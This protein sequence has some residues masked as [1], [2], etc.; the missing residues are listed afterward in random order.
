MISPEKPYSLEMYQSMFSLKVNSIDD[1][2]YRYAT[3]YDS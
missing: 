2:S 1:Y 3:I